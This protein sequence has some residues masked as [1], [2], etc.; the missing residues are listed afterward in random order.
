MKLAILLII[1]V[2][3]AVANAAVCDEMVCRR[4]VCGQPECPMGFKLKRN[5]GFCG[6]CDNCVRVLMEGEA[7]NPSD[8]PGGLPNEHGMTNSDPEC[9][10]NLFCERKSKTCARIF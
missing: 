1:A 8:S 9:G 2:C 7:C 10:L 5:G 6:C 4:I 3:V